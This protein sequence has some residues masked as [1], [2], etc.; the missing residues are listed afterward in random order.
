MRHQVSRRRG[1]SP[2]VTTEDAAWSNAVGRLLTHCGDLKPGE[3]LVIVSDNSTRDIGDVFAAEGR[4]TTDRV[5]HHVVGRAEVH[6]Q[7][8]PDS[9]ATVMAAGDLVIALTSRSIA[10][11]DARRRASLAG[12]RFL[13]LPEYSWDLL[14]DPSLS[15]DFRARAPLVRK[16]ADAFTAARQVRVTTRAGTDVTLDIAGRSGNFCPGFVDKPGSLGSPPDIEANVSPVES[17][18]NGRAIVDGSVAHPD[19]GL[20]RNP[21]ELIIEDGHVVSIDGRDRIV[22]A[23]VESLFRRVGSRKAYVLAECGVGLNEFASLTGTMLTDEGACGCVHFGFGSNATVGGRNEVPFH[24]DFVMRAA[25]LE[26]D[27]GVLLRDG[28]PTV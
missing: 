19:V 21:L 22:A 4:M 16:F 25:T 14:A 28:E 9:A 24:L 10:H 23:C 26:V 1:E 17:A 8:P 6:G 12:A 3:R 2:Q 18:S 27:G 11:T 20:L 7:E 13:S 15:A 5:S